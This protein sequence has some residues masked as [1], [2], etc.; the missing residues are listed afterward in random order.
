MNPLI[1]VFL[2][3]IVYIFNIK[4]NMAC[5]KTF[6]VND[7]LT[8]IWIYDTSCGR[9]T[10]FM[11]RVL[12]NFYARTYDLYDNMVMESI[13]IPSWD[14]TYTLTYPLYKVH[15]I[16][17]RWSGTMFH[18]RFSM[19]DYNCD[20]CTVKRIKFERWTHF[21]DDW[22]RKKDSACDDKIALRAPCEITN[23]S[24]VYSR[25]HVDVASV[26]STISM[27]D[28]LR[29]WLEILAEEMWSSKI[30]ELNN[31][32]YRNSQFER[33]LENAKKIDMEAPEFITMG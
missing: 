22:Q 14:S 3:I 11:N 19:T 6:T 25:W 7:F 21:L 23:A 13:S 2:F 5:N 15:W 10:N 17:W 16:Y 26:L 8:T 4:Y 30:E 1:G 32:S 27:T 12:R 20:W 9:K 28:Y 31:T 24:I 29:T 18:D 33:W